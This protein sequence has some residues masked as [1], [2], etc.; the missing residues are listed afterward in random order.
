VINVIYV[1]N[2]DTSLKT[3]D[4]IV[5]QMK[6][7]KVNSNKF[8]ILEV[9][10]I[11][12]VEE[13]IEIEEMIDTEEMTE[14]EEMIEIEEKIDIE[15]KIEIDVIVDLLVQVVAI[16][17]DV[18][19]ETNQTINVV[20]LVELL[21]KEMTILEEIDTYH[22]MIQNENLLSCISLPFIAF[23]G[24]FLIINASLIS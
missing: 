8:K 5:L 21:R 7:A 23:N 24:L 20:N 19:I 4:L 22:P 2:K 13:M 9:A 10:T 14:I 18:M 6:M 15:D 16:E 17:K 1:T 3:A 11:V 12:I